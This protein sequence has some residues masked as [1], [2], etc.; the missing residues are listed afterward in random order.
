VQ[1]QGPGVETSF[2]FE[3]FRQGQQHG[4][5]NPGVGLGLAIVRK[6]VELN[7]GSVRVESGAGAGL[8]VELPR[9]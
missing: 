2:T 4:V 7:H 1:D 8:V 9:A 3:P 6:L 5:K